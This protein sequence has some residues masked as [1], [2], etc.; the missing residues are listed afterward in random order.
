VPNSS[1]ENR[2]LRTSAESSKRGTARCAALLIAVAAALAEPALAADVP[3]PPAPP[4]MKRIPLPP[5]PPGMKLRPSTGP[6]QERCIACH[7]PV[8]QGRIVHT[9]MEKHACTACHK[10]V[11]AQAGKCKARTA[12]KWTLVKSEPDLCYGCHARK[13]TTK[14]VHTVVRQGSC[15]SCHAAHS[16]NFAGLIS[17]PREKV[18]LECHDVESVITKAV[19]HAPVLEGRCAD[20]HDPH[21][22]NLPNNVKAAGGTA[23]CLKCH[24][25]KAPQGK[26]T[27]GPGYRVDMSKKVLHSAFKRTDCLGCHDGGHSSDNLKF[28]KRSAVDLCYGCHER[29]DKNKYPHGAVV[30]GDCAVCHDPHSSDQPKLI[31]K[32]TSNET[33]FV[34]HQDDVTGRAFV[35]APVA[36]GCDQC[37]APH[38]AQSRNGLKAAEGKEGCY[39]CHKAVDTGKVKHAALER[40]GCTGCHDPHGGANRGFVPPSVNAACI[41]CHEGQKDGRHVS[42]MATN[43][44]VGGDLNDPRRQGRDF[45]CASCHNPHGSDNPKL[46]YFGETAL[47]SCDACHGDKEGRHPELQNVVHKA[48]RKALA[49]A[50]SGAGSPGAGSPGAGS[51]GAGSPGAGSPGSGSGAGAGGGESIEGNGGMA[52]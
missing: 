45:T 3:L 22:G 23:F 30:V 16:S 13:D 26:G 10:A 32:A 20:C 1:N 24:D 36:K 33:C 19:K 46:F 11:P 40:Y 7:S 50:N 2:R 51:P 17:L 25:A 27:P 14:S 9:A 43:H 18:C 15:L 8:M 52:R 38:G 29:K 35:H 44:P 31:T 4:G 39:K 21:G 49:P 47:N 42:P 37:H 5:P 6:T 41:T 48:R 28:L 12:S 34:C